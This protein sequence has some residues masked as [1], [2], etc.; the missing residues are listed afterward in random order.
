MLC[1]DNCCV[2][3]YGGFEECLFRRDLKYWRSFVYGFF[4]LKNVYFY[5]IFICLGICFLL[6]V[7]LIKCLLMFGIR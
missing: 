7:F 3:N 2:I 1:K 5:F 6:F 4:N